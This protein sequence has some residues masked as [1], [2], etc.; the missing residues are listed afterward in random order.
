MLCME[1]VGYI[2]AFLYR[3]NCSIFPF[4][5][6]LEMVC[7]KERQKK[8][9]KKLVLLKWGRLKVLSDTKLVLNEHK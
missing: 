1:K 3:K 6:H 7:C 5:L 8:S 9:V 2:K 4:N